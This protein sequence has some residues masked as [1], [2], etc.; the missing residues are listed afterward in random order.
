MRLIRNLVKG[1]VRDITQ[2]DTKG[3]PHLPHHDEATA[4]GGRGAF[5]SVNGNSGRFGSNTQPKK[6]ASNEEMG[7]RVGD[8]LPNASEE[9]ND[10]AYEDSATTTKPTIERFGEPATKYSTA[11]LQG[12]SEMTQN[13]SVVPPTYGAELTRPRSHWFFPVLPWFGSM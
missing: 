4:N 10:S 6:E 7:P 2:H 9:R 5:G 11:E 12:R 3:S 8:A 1:K 13:E